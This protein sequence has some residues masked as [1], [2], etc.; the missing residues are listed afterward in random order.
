M[1]SVDLFRAFFRAWFYVREL[2]GGRMSGVVL[3]L[4]GLGIAGYG[5]A[6]GNKSGEAR[7]GTAAPVVVTLPARHAEPAPP[8][9]PQPAFA[10][11]DRETLARELQKEL[12]RVGCYSGEI[13]GVWT[14][15]TRRAMKAFTERV[16][17][18]LP[19]GEPDGVLY[20]MVQGQPDRVCGTPCPAGQSR[21]HEGP[22]V[23][24]MILAR[25]AGRALPAALAP[26]SHP[27]TDRRAPA[28]AGW[29]AA[30][31]A[32][33]LVT[34]EHPAAA[35][36]PAPPPAPPQALA[37]ALLLPEPAEGRMALAGPNVEDGLHAGRRSAKAPARTRAARGRRLQRA[38]PVSIARAP[39][40]SVFARVVFRRN[41]SG[42]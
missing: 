40:Q 17:A 36:P 9:T 20:A 4:A 41:D 10:P 5:L 15:A 24:G 42:Y 25:P 37:A 16:N 13:N 2:A 35:A 29:S 32:P 26:A 21:S 8:P 6:P 34:P 38:R 33:S 18:S 3:I 7:E 22:C 14:H 27:S 11:Q 1:S 23:P 30:V 31:T 28:V 39:R 19:V 12:K